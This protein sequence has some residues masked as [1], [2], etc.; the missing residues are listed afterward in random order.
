MS[1]AQTVT[2][3]SF[4]AYVDVQ[5]LDT[6][7]VPQT[8]TITHQQVYDLLGYWDCLYQSAIDYCNK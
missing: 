2:S 4:Q 8:E 7:T 1:N 3:K 5:G 6:I